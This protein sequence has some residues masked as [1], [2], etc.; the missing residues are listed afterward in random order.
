[1]K[2][3]GSKNEYNGSDQLSDPGLSRYTVDST[4]RVYTLDSAASLKVRFY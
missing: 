2:H 3:A 4:G 1:M